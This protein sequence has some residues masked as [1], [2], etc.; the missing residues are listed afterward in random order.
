MSLK[1]TRQVIDS[2]LDGSLVI[3]GGR[4]CQRLDSC[5]PRCQR[6]GL[7][8]RTLALTE[9]FDLKELC[10]HDYVGASHKGHAQLS[11]PANF[12]KVEVG[13]TFVGMVGLIDPPR[14]KCKTAIQVCR[15]AGIS[16][17]MFT[18]D[19][20]ITAEAIAHSLGILASSDKSGKS[21]PGHELDHKSEAE[22][23]DPAAHHGRAQRR[24]CR[25]FADGAKAQASYREDIEAVGRDRGDDQRR[26]ERCAS[27]EAGRHR[28]FHRQHWH[29]GCQGGIGHGVGRRIF[30]TI[31]SA[32]EGELGDG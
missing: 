23:S 21:F 12:V 16:V 8:L 31:V 9:R 4:R 3:V 27:L 29:R 10:L 13:P 28:D 19:N 24:R 15:V 25:V 20:K 30:S 2:I 17:I 1:Y 32:V 18:G 22:D 14:P 11:G 7:P 26:R 6:F 5:I